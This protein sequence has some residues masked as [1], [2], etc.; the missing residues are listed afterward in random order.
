MPKDAALATI[1]PFSVALSISIPSNPWP[2]QATPL[3]PSILP[4]ESKK[5]LLRG[6]PWPCKTRD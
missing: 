2:K 5:A 4:T 6:N 3:N 1:I